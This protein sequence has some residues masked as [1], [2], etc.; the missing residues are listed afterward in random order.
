MSE[1]ILQKTLQISQKILQN[2]II[3]AKNSPPDVFFKIFYN[4]TKKCL[5]ILQAVI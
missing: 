4:F 5:V 1:K 2:V 3:L